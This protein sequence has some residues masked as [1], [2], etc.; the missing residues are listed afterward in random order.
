V[1]FSTKTIIVR[2]DIEA[3]IRKD[4]RKAISRLGITTLPT[5]ANTPT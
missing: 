4:T 3:T 2:S 1:S 5:T